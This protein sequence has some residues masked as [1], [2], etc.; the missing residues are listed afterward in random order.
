VREATAAFVREQPIHYTAV[1]GM[2]SLREAVA[3]ELSAYHGT[4]ITASRVLISNGAKQSIVNYLLA[5]IDPGDQVVIPTPAWVS[6]PDM[7]RLAEGEPVLVPTSPDHGWRLQP[8]A[9]ARAIGPRTK[10]LMLNSPCNPTGA[11][12]REQDLRALGEVLAEHAPQAFVLAD[13]IYRMLSYPPRRHASLVRALAGISD[14]VVLV[15]GVSKTYAMTGYRIGFLVAPEP[16]TAAATRIQGQTT[17][18][19]ATPSQHAALVALTDPT[20][21]ADVQTMYEAFARRRDTMLAALA[22]VAELRIV[23][24]EGAFYTWIDVTRVLG[25]AV[26]DDVAL[27]SWLLERHGVATVDGT[28]FGGPGHIRLSYATD[29]A[30]VAA[31]CAKLC[32]AFAELRGTPS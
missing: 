12:Y 30:S 26:A 1:A 15:D 20:V 6:Y 9:L 32:E 17:S 5:T 2:A 22:P 10:L 27:A 11:C 4:P 25:G 21:P 19:A 16:V 13:D 8:D 14:R 3:S 24:P 23:P 28:S 18:G 31:G 7:V 29:D